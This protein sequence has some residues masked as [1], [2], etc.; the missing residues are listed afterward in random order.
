MHV[1]NITD[2]ELGWL[3]G[4]ASSLTR[5]LLGTENVGLKEGESSLDLRTGEYLDLDRLPNDKGDQRVRGMLCGFTRDRRITQDSS[6]NNPVGFSND[7][8]EN[9]PVSSLSFFIAPTI[10]RDASSASFIN[11]DECEDYPSFYKMKVDLADTAFGN[12]SSQFVLVGIA[13]EPEKNEVRMYADGNLI[14]TSSISKVFGVDPNKT[15]SLPNF[16]QPNSFE[17]SSTTVDGPFIL[18]QG[19]TLYDFLSPCG[20]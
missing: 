2:G 11:N 1:P 16:K 9:D 8:A 15:P 6:E 18:K 7:N 19:P 4:G 10:S 17:Y 3:S 20:S 13:C 14:A 12:V 5:V